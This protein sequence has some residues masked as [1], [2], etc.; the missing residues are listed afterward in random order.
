MTEIRAF[1]GHSFTDDDAD[2]VSKFIGYFEQL[3]T[4]LPNFI[5]EHAQVAEPKELPTKVLQLF[6]DKNT[7]IGICTKK[8]A[9][10]SAGAL[11]RPLLRANSRL[12][13]SRDIEAKTSDWIIQE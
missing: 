2:V 13:D 8:E 5:W 1:V 11:R 12:V 9:A 3:A 4:T 10:I 7:F 6:A